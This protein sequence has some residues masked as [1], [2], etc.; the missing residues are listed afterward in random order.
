MFSLLLRKESLVFFFC[1]RGQTAS[2]SDFWFYK[3]ILCDGI[4]ASERIGKQGR[5]WCVCRCVK[6]VC[7]YVIV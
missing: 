4:I 5:F 1:W 2:D 3:E 6:C 7:L